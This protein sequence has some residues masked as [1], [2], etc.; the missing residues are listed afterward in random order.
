VLAARRSL[1]TR[2]ARAAMRM[3]HTRFG[4]T[5]YRRIPPR[6]LDALKSRLR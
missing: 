1:R 4:A 2:V 3:R 5:L 6:L